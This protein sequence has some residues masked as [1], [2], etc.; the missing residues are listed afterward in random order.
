MKLRN[1]TNYVESSRKMTLTPTK[2]MC[3]SLYFGFTLQNYDLRIFRVCH[4]FFY[5]T[6]FIFK[7]F[8][9]HSW[10]ASITLRFVKLY[11]IN[12]SISHIFRCG[13]IFLRHFKSCPLRTKWKWK[14][15]EFFSSSI[16]VICVFVDSAL[17]LFLPVFLCQAAHNVCKMWQRSK[18]GCVLLSSFIYFW[19]FNWK[20]KLKICGFER[21]K[22][23]CFPY[24]LE[25]K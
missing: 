8:Y 9:S 23:Y 22:R 1:C 12:C 16:Y 6:K 4:F 21:R 5:F 3:V 11:T 15:K 2:W 14:W 24:V 13:C 20:Q 7:M 18:I 25:F 17:A 19:Y 10:V